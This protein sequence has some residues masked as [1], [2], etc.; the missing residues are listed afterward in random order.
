MHQFE[1]YW[2]GALEQLDDYLINIQKEG[3]LK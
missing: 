3:K 2:G 1:M